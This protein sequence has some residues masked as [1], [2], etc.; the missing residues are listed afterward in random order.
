MK[1][2]KPN[3]KTWAKTRLNIQLSQTLPIN[4]AQ[5]INSTCRVCI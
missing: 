3:Q 5:D 2:N 1:T 4:A